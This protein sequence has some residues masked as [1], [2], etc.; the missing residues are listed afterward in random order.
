MDLW[1]A[2]SG[3]WLDGGLARIGGSPGRT[4]QSME[5]S[6]DRLAGCAAL[7]RWPHLGKGAS[8]ERPGGAGWRITGLS[9]VVVPLRQPA[10]SVQCNRIDVS[11]PPVNGMRR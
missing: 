5:A 6:S 10:T 4:S 2:N 8:R 9:Q 3:G 7:A 1:Q 11:Q